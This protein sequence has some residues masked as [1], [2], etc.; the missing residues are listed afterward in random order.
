[1]H[2]SHNE[3]SLENVT[4][5]DSSIPTGGRV[6]ISWLPLPQATIG[7]PSICLPGYCR[8]VLEV[9][10]YNEGFL[11]AV[12]F[13]P[14]LLAQ[15]YTQGPRS[16]E[17]RL[18]EIFNLKGI[19]STEPAWGKEGLAPRGYTP[20]PYLTLEHPF[21]TC[22]THTHTCPAWSLSLLA[23]AQTFHVP[24]TSSLQVINSRTY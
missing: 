23:K 14:S 10:G 21:N 7:S 9:G 19:P 24:L 12:C 18:G 8:P 15:I 22:I 6:L 13:I 3:V 1:M 5:S 11:V 17:G 16:P 4:W 20:W 2:F